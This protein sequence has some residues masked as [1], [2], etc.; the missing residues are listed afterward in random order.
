MNA[1]PLRRVSSIPPVLKDDALR[2]STRARLLDAIPKGYSPWIHLACTT[3]IAVTLLALGVWGV[4]GL[5]A[6]EL[7]VVPIVFL[8]A[9]GFEW[10]AH[11]DLLHKVRWP[12]GFLYYRH[13]PEH[14]V[15]YVEEDMAIRD[16]RELR[17]V[18][19]PA[20]GVFGIVLTIAPL[21]AGIGWLTTANAG[22]L[23][24][25]TA[26]LYMVAYELSHLSYHLPAT[27]FVGRLALVRV[28]RRHHARHHD[29]RLMQRWN[30]NVTIPLFDYLHGTVA[31]PRSVIRAPKR[32][33]EELAAAE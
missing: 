21:A 12:M 25:V 11:K 2:R 23:V 10:R 1:P 33:S 13:T 20:W 31:P 14:H 4:H 26:G 15:V 17:L 30:F 16:W 5:R 6:V 32:A 24:L 9:N 18:L 29:P 28:L 22:W 19:I 27:S 7:L 3:G 8:I